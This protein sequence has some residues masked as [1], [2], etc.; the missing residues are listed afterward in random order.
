MAP[1]GP[2]VVTV[3]VVEHRDIGAY[4]LYSCPP[5]DDGK[6]VA[7]CGSARRRNVENVAPNPHVSLTGALTLLPNAP[8][9]QLIDEQRARLAE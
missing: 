2:H 3:G 9:V 6:H 1:P 8:E 5:G 7:D 4:H